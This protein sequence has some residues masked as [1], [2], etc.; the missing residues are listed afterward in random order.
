VRFRRL[1]HP[2]TEDLGVDLGTSNTLVYARGRGIVVNEPSVISFCVATGRVEAVGSPAKEMLGRTPRGVIAVEPLK[3]GVIAHLEA[4]QVMLAHFIREARG[5]GRVVVG[6]PGDST[7]IERRAV[8]EAAYRAGACGVRLVKESL[9]AA[10]GAGVS[11]T[12]PA[13]NMIVDIGSG[14]TDV[15][16]ISLAGVTHELAV[17]VAGN[18]MD[19]AII[20]CVKQNHG[21]EIG[22]RTAERV[23]KE[24]GSAC[25]PD[26]PLSAQA[27]GRDARE[28]LPRTVVL[29]DG[30]IREAL[31]A[32]LRSI[33]A[34]VRG[35]LDR[36]PPELSADIVDRGII[37]TGGGALV[38][39]L[40]ALLSAETGAAVSVA[41]NP[42]LSVAYGAGMILEDARLLNR[43]T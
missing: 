39:K 8:E 17:R 19:E 36:T 11:I 2:F 32:P 13:G 16:V 4:T 41:E 31:S 10:V 29:T 27:R 34:A 25:P 26:V 22:K 38:R 12:D 33:V 24:L 37:L 14:T 5:G 42:L 23:K 9:A 18:V 35:A 21:L 20:D 40:D 30:E 3:G 1:L 6:V 28:G 15:A 7:E 43:L